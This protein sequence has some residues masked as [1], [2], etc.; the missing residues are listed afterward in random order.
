MTIK[1]A[2]TS[3]D[4]K[5]IDQHFGH[6]MNFSIAEINQE[7]S[8]WKMV[9]SRKTARTCHEFSHDAEQVEQVVDSLSDCDYLLTYRIGYYPNLLF[10]SKG[11]QCVETPTEEPVTIEQGIARL[12]SITQSMK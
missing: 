9:D 2:V 11:I 4:G 6:C 7:D 10:S 3:S 8:S 5:R 12:L 1:V